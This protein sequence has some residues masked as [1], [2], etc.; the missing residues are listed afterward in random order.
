[1]FD[2]SV[3]WTRE[4]E[5]FLDIVREKEKMLILNKIDLPAVFSHN[6]LLA[7]IPEPVPTLHISISQ[8]TGLD[9]LKQAIVDEV[10]DIPL[11][12]VAV[13]NVRHKQALSSAQKSLIHAQESA[14][15]QMSQEFIALDIR[16]ALDHLGDITGE[17]TTEDILGRIFSTFCIGK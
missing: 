13:T 1:M 10:I 11:E 7:K 17:T 2:I 4:D 6:E 15:A 9:E 14:T 3:P 5:H 12:S 8:H 16:D